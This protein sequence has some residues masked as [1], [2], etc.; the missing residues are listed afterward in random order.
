FNRLPDKV[1]VMV[2]SQYKKMLHQNDKEGIA[3]EAPLLVTFTHGKGTVIFTSFHNEK[4]TS[5]V[6]KKLLQYLVFKLVT[7]KVDAEV[8]STINQG[9]F[10]PQPSNLLSA[11]TG[12]KSFERTYASK[13][14]GPLR[15]ALAFRNEEGV[16]LGLT[17]Q[18]PDGKKYTKN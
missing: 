15:F 14:D 8:A 3:S 2:R 9:G 5:E 11:P 10:E 13:K 7:A 17:I 12:K 6:E 1:N 4:Q 18:S 16:K